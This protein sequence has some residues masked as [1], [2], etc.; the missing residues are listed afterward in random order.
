MYLHCGKTLKYIPFEARGRT[1]ESMDVEALAR[2]RFF[3]RNLP[4]LLNMAFDGWLE[5]GP[6][7]SP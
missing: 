5:L 1:H 6:Q 7:S 4:R 2:Q 3:F